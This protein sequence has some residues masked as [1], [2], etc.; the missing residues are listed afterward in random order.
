MPAKSIRIAYLKR[1]L[2][3]L[4]VEHTRLRDLLA[5]G[6]VTPE[7][8][9]LGTQQLAKHQAQLLTELRS[10]EANDAPE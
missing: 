1:M 10:L 8:A 6:E 4:E 7:E 3:R 9:K 2:K 5:A